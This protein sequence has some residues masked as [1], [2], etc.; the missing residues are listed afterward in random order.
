M[1][2]GLRDSLPNNFG[3][4]QMF[5]M[6]NEDLFGED[7]LRRR[8]SATTMNPKH[9][10]KIQ[11]AIGGTPG[12]GMSDREIVIKSQDSFEVFTNNEPEGTPADCCSGFSTPDPYK[13]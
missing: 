2:V 10:N 11:I 3:K 6:E 12:T 5:T 8:A 13:I 4:D 1:N 7:G 9:K